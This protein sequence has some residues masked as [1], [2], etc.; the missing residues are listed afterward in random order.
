[1]EIKG[2]HKRETHAHSVRQA[3][4]KAIDKLSEQ[5]NPWRSTSN[6][7]P[8]PAKI[9]IEVK[10]LEGQYVAYLKVTETIDPETVQA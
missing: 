4:H 6:P 8:I 9:E 7:G 5:T 2:E 10:S 1:M 3:V